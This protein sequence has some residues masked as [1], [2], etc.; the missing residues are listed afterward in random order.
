MLGN[1]P[2]CEVNTEKCIL[3]NYTYGIVT[4]LNE[5]S[6]TITSFS[7][8]MSSHK[9]LENDRSSICD[10]QGTILYIFI[11]NKPHMADPSIVSALHYFC[12]MES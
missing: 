1:Y 3:I 10:N 12:I 2:Q 5:V 7:A 4:T 11:S 8:V 6:V 9:V